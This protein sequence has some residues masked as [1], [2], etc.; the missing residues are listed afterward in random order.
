[1]K[2]RTTSSESRVGKE[3]KLTIRNRSYDVADKRAV[4]GSGSVA[5]LGE[6]SL[7]RVLGETESQLTSGFPCK[8]VSLEEIE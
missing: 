5:L 6:K 8:R 7:Q 1:M 2:L 3:E 4:G